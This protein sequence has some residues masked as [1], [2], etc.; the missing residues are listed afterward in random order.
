MSGKDCHGRQDDDATAT[1]AAAAAGGATDG[2]PMNSIGGAEN[3]Y[4]TLN[5]GDDVHSRTPSS[6]PPPSQQQQ[7]QL[8]RSMPSPSKIAVRIMN[9][10]SG[11]CADPFHYHSFANASSG[12][13]VPTPRDLYIGA[14]YKCIACH[15]RLGHKPPSSSTTNIARSTNINE[16]TY[17]RPPPLVNAETNNSTSTT[18]MLHCIA[19]GV[20]AHRTCAFSRS[21]LQG[22][23]AESVSS[24]W[25]TRIPVCKINSHEIQRVCGDRRGAAITQQIKEES[26]QPPIQKEATS[27]SPSSSSSSWNI[28]GKRSV[29]DESQDNTIDATGKI[30]TNDAVETSKGDADNNYPSTTITG[31]K[32]E[33]IAS[34]KPSST[35]SSSS[36]SSSSWNIFRKNNPL[37]NESIDVNAKNADDNEADHSSTIKATI[38]NIENQL[39]SDN[40]LE[41]KID[42][43]IATKQPIHQ[44]PPPPPPPPPG[45]IESSIQ[46]IKKTTET[47]IHI[48][49]ASAIGMVA[50]GAAGW[51]LAGPAGIIVGSQI[52]RT[53]LTVGAVVEGGIGIAMLAINL[54]Q[55]AN[56]ALTPSSRS[57]EKGEREL[58]LNN[59]VLVLVRPDIEVDPIWGVYANEARSAWQRERREHSSTTAASTPSGFALGSL[60]TSSTTTTASSNEEPNMR[61]LKDS[62]IVKAD[63]NELPTKD[64]VF[65]LV[66]RILNDK[67]S[68]P[69]YQYRFLIMKHK[70]RTMFGEYDTR[71]TINT[72]AK[73]SCRQDAHGIIKHVTAT[74]L[75]VR[76]GLASSST[77]T[78]LTAS[79]VEALIFGE[80]YNECFDE[81]I[82][83]TRENGESLTAKVEYLRRRCNNDGC[84]TVLRNDDQEDATT[85]TATSPPPISLSAIAALQLLPKAHTPTDKLL[86]CV[87]FLEL[88]SAY[89]SSSSFNNGNTNKCIDA[90]SLLA[91]VCQHVVTANIPHLHA[92]VAFIDEFSRDEQLLS[93]KEGYALITLQASLHYLDSLEELPMEM[94]SVH[95][96]VI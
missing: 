62:D 58:K 30:I 47:T 75:E 8:V 48:P 80:L 49:T 25:S 74:L 43:P 7:Q 71:C 96:V 3:Y 34:N 11:L 36:S 87:E 56:F 84:S 52:G 10:T 76:P 37:T 45:V 14:F 32:V 1:T 85:T 55:A 35:S 50:G 65:L 9:I 89:Y 73:R 42:P 41:K 53:V 33:P 83:Q 20:Y 93:G 64:K 27:P 72:A 4:D 92:E 12:W 17:W 22:K 79:A 63:A 81:I 51:V 19:C 2:A 68:L 91:M 94:M 82:D 54:A 88:I 69:G 31:E 29:T 21:A 18:E 46:L 66:N 86:Y 44:P 13:V 15:G 23:T 67:T 5:D 38:T 16:D 39:L 70:R 78:E 24:K 40:V 26:L 95:S 77:M 90:D 60:F 59:G 61:Y 6:C 57:S 28:F